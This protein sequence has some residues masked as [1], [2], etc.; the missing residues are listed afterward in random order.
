M[1]GI[2]YHGPKILAN[3]RNSV[4]NYYAEEKQLGTGNFR[5]EMSEKTTFE[6]GTNHFVNL[7]WLF[8]ETNFV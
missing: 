7:F 3:S 5:F 2:P 4:P 1:Q 6:V 8:C